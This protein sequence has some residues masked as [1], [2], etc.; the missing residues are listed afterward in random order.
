MVNPSFVNDEIYLIP[1]MYTSQ[2]LHRSSK[3]NFIRYQSRPKYDQ[4]LQ[5]LKSQ[6]DHTASRRHR[7]SEPVCQNSVEG[8]DRLL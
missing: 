6:V 2:I 3:I 8:V 4:M 5:L 1:H 7:N